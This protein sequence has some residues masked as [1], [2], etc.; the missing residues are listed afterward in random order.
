MFADIARRASGGA[1]LTEFSA[2]LNSSYGGYVFPELIGKKG[3]A[4]LCSGNIGYIWYI[5]YIDASHYMA[6]TKSVY[7]TWGTVT[8]DPATGRVNCGTGFGGTITGWA[9]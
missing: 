7:A 8:F 2:T 4:M 5:V 6:P 9:W 1:E 3:F